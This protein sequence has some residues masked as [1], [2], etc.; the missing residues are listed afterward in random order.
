MNIFEVGMSKTIEDIILG[1]NKDIFHSFL[2][3]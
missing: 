1:I 2:I 3:F